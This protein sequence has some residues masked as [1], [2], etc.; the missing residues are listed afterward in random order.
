MEP[1]RREFPRRKAL[2]PAVFTASVATFLVVFLGCVVYVY[3]AQEWFFS[4]ARIK[5][6]PRSSD[7]QSLQTELEI[8]RSEMFLAPIVKAYDLT[9][10]WGKRYTPGYGPLKTSA[11]T[12]R[13][14]RMLQLRLVENTT[15]VDIGV[16]SDRSEEAAKLANAI[17]EAYQQRAQGVVILDHAT[18]SSY[19]YSP[20]RPQLVFSG[21]WGGF[22]LGVL[23]GCVVW[24]VSTYPKGAK[25][26]FVDAAPAEAETSDELLS[27]PTS[28][29]P[30]TIASP[31]I[32]DAFTGSRLRFI[33]L[34]LVCAIAFGSYILG[35]VTFLLDGS[36]TT[37]KA[38]SSSGSSYRWL[39]SMLHEGSALV[40]LW[41]VLKRQGR[42]F[43]DL[44]LCWAWKDLGWSVVLWVGTVIV[45][46]ATYW[47]ISSSGLAPANRAAANNQ[48]ENY[49][50]G[51]GIY[52]I[53]LLYALLNPFFEELIVRAYLMTEIKRLTNSIFLAVI[54][55]TT[56]Q[57]SYHYYQ[58]AGLAL[59]YGSQFLLY[60]MFYARTNRIA[61]VILVHLYCD[62]GAT[63][64]YMLRH[65]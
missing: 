28:I 8:M 3:T 52:A 16:A 58:G 49:L 35:F 14:K 39:Q 62:V 23:V 54:I 63:L 38:T 2:E 41:Y 55:S 17:A 40:L 27:L 10:E 6:E 22:M 20:N 36:P 60:S 34:L 11:C 57:T 53:T 43:F 64:S 37:T 15:I 45:Q 47:L 61:P 44:G 30:S 42:R 7:S 56:L 9:E 12:E 26:P 24:F 18:R 4:T 48:I 50:F 31:I 65:H 25:T 19:P 29:T 33:E 21:L 1:L 5:L 59:S 51:G 32:T 13:L 46:P